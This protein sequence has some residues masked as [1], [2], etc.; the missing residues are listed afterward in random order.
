M[1]REG[2][3]FHP[4][5]LCGFPKRLIQGLIEEAERADALGVPVEQAARGRQRQHCF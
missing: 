2:H 5:Q 3:D 1:G 4:E